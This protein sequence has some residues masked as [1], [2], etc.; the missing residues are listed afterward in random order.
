ML[1]SGNPDLLH[2]ARFEAG[3][4][5]GTTSIVEKEKDVQATTPH[6]YLLGTTS[7]SEKE[8]DVQATAPHSYLLGT[9]SISENEKDVQATAPHGYPI[10][11]VWLWPFFLSCTAMKELFIPQ[12][13]Q[14]HPH[15]RGCWQKIRTAAAALI[16]GVTSAADLR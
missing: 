4:L 3:I 2:P 14:V 5:P 11:Q 12:V 8:E 16:S 15:N 7:I 9:T 1:P 13:R 10:W 6:S